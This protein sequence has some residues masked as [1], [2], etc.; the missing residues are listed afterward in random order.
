MSSDGIVDFSIF[1]FNPSINNYTIILVI[2]QGEVE[3]KCL[4]FCS[5]LRFAHTYNLLIRFFTFFRIAH[6]F[7][8]GDSRDRRGCRN[9][10][11]KSKNSGKRSEHPTRMGTP[12]FLFRTPQLFLATPQ[13]SKKPPQK[14]SFEV[15]SLSINFFVA[16]QGRI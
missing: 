8:A 6:L 4:T 12:H 3:N 10:N 1:D 9:Y 15:V 7:V 5:H 14:R 11:S 2:L 16:T 13:K